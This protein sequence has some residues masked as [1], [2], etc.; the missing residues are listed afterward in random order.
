ML[1]YNTYSLDTGYALVETVTENDET[2][3]RK[4]VADGLTAKKAF[5]MRDRYNLMEERAERGLNPSLG[6][7]NYDQMMLDQGIFPTGYLED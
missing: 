4:V 3:S 2:V 5:E 6:D 1:R 7:S